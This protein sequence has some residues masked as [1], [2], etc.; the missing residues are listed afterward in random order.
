MEGATPGGAKS[1]SFTSAREAMA[2]PLA[3]RLFQIDGV[4]QAG[5]EAGGSLMLPKRFMFA[6]LSLRVYEPNSKNA[7]HVRWVYREVY[8][9]SFCTLLLVAS[10]PACAAEPAP[11]PQPH[12]TPPHPFAERPHHTTHTLQTMIQIAFAV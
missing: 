2:S 5:G 8:A 3:K 9:P 7:R 12:P 11:S 10:H 4:T 6:A 1:K